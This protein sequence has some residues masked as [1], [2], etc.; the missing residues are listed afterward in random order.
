[1][2]EIIDSRNN[3]EFTKIPKIQEKINIPLE[4]IKENDSIID[5][6]IEFKSLDGYKEFIDYLN[7]NQDQKNKLAQMIRNL[8]ASGNI[9]QLVE[10]FDSSSLEGGVGFLDGKKSTINLLEEKFKIKISEN[11]EQTISQK[12]QTIS[13]KEQTSTQEK[14]TS[15]NKFTDILKDK[16]PDIYKKFGLDKAVTFDEK[17]IVLKKDYDKILT[18]IKNEAKKPGGNYD[19]YISTIHTFKD[20]GIISEVEF[21]KYLKDIPQ[22][23]DLIVKD[24]VGLGGYDKI[25][26]SYLKKGENSDMVVSGGKTT[27]IGK[28]GFQLSDYYTGKEDGQ[29]LLEK[30]KLDDSISSLKSS[31]SKIDALFRIMNSFRKLEDFR[32]L[33]ED[34]KLEKI[35]GAETSKKL[36]ASIL[37]GISTDKSDSIKI[38]EMLFDS[39]MILQDRKDSLEDDMKSEIE[40]KRIFEFENKDVDKYAEKFK[41]K[42]DIMQSTVEAVEANGW[43][44]FGNK[45]NI[46][47]FLNILKRYDPASEINVD[48]GKG[49]NFIKSQGKINKWF[50]K[51]LDIS[52]S[53]LYSGADG[54][55]PPMKPFIDLIPTDKA[56]RTKLES[57]GIMRNGILNEELLKNKIE[58]ISTKKDMAEAEKLIQFA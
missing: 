9:N 35:L 48:L 51:I 13:Q 52:P 20:I 16:Y 57:S 18:E 50:A 28:E 40:K 43:N 47:S 26:D 44:V 42:E 32:G 55:T 25:G 38:N 11:I 30:Q 24:A 27:C 33:I 58:S 3:Q 6:V 8:K 54:F 5:N 36:K 7:I 49:L 46:I 31:I 10:Y 23:K 29:K 4:I 37:S 15:L 17:M 21:N 34:P 19:D 41:N 14:Q 12:E 22:Q 45:N 56:I 1:M 39:T 53:A 2:A